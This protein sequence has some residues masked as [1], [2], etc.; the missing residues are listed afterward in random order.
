M[1]TLFVKRPR[2]FFLSV[3]LIGLGFGF[4]KVLNQ[5]V[6]L[7]YFPDLLDI[8]LIFIAATVFMGD[9]LK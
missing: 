4:I 8:S 2:R 3:I 5:W 7:P 9:A 6:F 1:K